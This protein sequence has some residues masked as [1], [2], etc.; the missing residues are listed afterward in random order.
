MCVRFVCT[1]SEHGPLEGTATVCQTYLV[2]DVLGYNV[3]GSA[4]KH[5][6]GKLW[7]G[8]ERCEPTVGKKLCHEFVH[9]IKLHYQRLG[10]C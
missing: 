9:Q 3:H 2:L 10:C 1:G 8:L 6:A 4:V 7:F 5:E